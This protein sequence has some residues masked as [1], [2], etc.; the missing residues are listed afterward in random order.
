MDNSSN[1]NIL[2]DDIN[3]KKFIGSIKRKRKFIS[4]FTLFGAIT[5]TI[6]TLSKK[7]I[8]Q[9]DFQIIVTNDKPMSTN[10]LDQLDALSEFFENIS[11][12]DLTQLEILKSPSVLLP[13]FNYIK[14][15]K[16][17]KS[18]QRYL[19]KKNKIEGMKKQTLLLE[20]KM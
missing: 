20:K 2:N 5:S 8:W 6:I 12:D 18:N 7:D 1:Q 13:V 15:E 14:Q 11:N 19:L 3:L 4:L 16:K 17:S 10:K 9:G